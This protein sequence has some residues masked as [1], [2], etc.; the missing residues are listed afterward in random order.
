MKKIISVVI[1]LVIILI[2]F[3][4]ITPKQKHNS[5]I[6]KPKAT[7]SPTPKSNSEAKMNQEKPKAKYV[8]GEALIKFKEEIDDE[9]ARKIIA[10]YNC[11]VIEKIASINVYKIN[12]PKDKTVEEMVKVLNQDSRVKYAEPNYLFTLQ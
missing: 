10:E 8:E 2:L 12:L 4:W 5:D 1:L 7:N 3:I 6:V 11:K 9:T